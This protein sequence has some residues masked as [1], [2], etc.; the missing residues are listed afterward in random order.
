MCGQQGF[1]AGFLALGGHAAD[2]I[3]CR[4]GFCFAL[5]DTHHDSDGLC[6]IGDGIQRAGEGA[7]FAGLAAGGQ[8]VGN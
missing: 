5:G 6:L 1:H 7:G 3:G 2:D 8:D 4:L